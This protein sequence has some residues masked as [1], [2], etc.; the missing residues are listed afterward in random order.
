MGTSRSSNGCDRASGARKRLIAA[1]AVTTCIGLFASD[2][3]ANHDPLPAAY[4]T[5][6]SYETLAGLAPS[7]HASAL[8]AAEGQQLAPHR[9]KRYRARDFKV[10][11]Y[12]REVKLLKEDVVVRMKSPGKRK[13]LF[14]LEV[15]F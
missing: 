6:T 14:M 4:I 12:K 5:I 13:S 11:D 1:L 7:Q 9:A 10:I 2:A 15:N 8:L 3:L